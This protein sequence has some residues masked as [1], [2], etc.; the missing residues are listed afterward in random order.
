MP[1]GIIP[2]SV[3]IHRNVLIKINYAYQTGVIKRITG[4]DYLVLISYALLNVQDMLTRDMEH[5][6]YL[7]KVSIH[8]PVLYHTDWRRW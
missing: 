2:V 6:L 8:H 4:G 1:S 5:S 7:L 3:G